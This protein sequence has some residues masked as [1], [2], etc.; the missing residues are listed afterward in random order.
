M[1]VVEESLDTFFLIVGAVSIT[2]KRRHALARG[3]CS[4]PLIRNYMH[5][6][7]QIAVCQALVFFM[8][9]GFAMIAVGSINVMNLAMATDFILLKNML[10]ISLG[11]LAWWFVGYGLVYGKSGGFGGTSK[12]GL[13][14]EDFED[15]PVNGSSHGSG[16]AYG[17]CANNIACL[18]CHIHHNHHH[19]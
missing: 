11:A 9:V 10:D 12:F 7:L 4:A 15:Q 14:K 2:S 13:A 3:R 19:Q 8:Q 18:S 6:H 16:Y 5:L 17:P 1:E